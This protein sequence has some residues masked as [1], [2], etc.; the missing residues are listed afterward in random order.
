MVNIE[1]N[2]G[3]S[4][5]NR[6]LLK[7]ALTRRAYALEQKQQKRAYEDQEIYRVLGDAVLKVVLVD[8]LI[9]SGSKT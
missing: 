4:F 8:L 2:L 3:Y 6:N 9:Q 1:A 7:R 5:V